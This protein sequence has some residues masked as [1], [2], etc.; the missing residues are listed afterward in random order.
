MMEERP[1]RNGVCGDTNNSEE[2]RSDCSTSGCWRY[3]LDGLMD[4]HLPDVQGDA[5]IASCIRDALLY[6][7]AEFGTVSEEQ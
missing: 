4:L 3:V 1:H 7:S 6:G 2:Q 5:G